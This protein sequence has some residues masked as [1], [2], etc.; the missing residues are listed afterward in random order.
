MEVRNIQSP[1]NFKLTYYVSGEANEEAVV[2]FNAPGM[3]VKFWIPIISELSKKYK[4][5]CM[6]YRGFP[7]GTEQ[8]TLEDLSFDKIV[9]DFHHIIEHENVSSFHALSWCLGAKVKLSLYQK[10]PEKI[11]SMHSLNMAFKRS[12]GIEKGPFSRMVQQLKKKLETGESSISRIIKIM[13]SIGTI[14][15]TDFL[16]II[17]MEEDNTTLNLYEFLENESSMSSLAFYLIDNKIGLMNYLNIYSGFSANDQVETLR[18]IKIPVYVYIGEKDK[19]VTF[20]PEDT[21]L[22]E[23]N[24]I[25]HP[26]VIEEG[27]HF[28]LIEY[29][30]RMSRIL[31]EKLTNGAL[32]LQ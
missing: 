26:I 8:L 24:D 2:I 17:D 12:D 11:I 29:A 25:I 20:K 31:D 15:N 6:E 5:L 3:S 30:K 22:F 4:I 32:K 18:N 19:M 10:H 27:S 7:D 14:P 28:M 13:S 16:S 21:A 1:D 23:S 9:N